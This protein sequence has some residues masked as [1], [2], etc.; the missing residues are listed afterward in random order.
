V[1]DPRLTRVSG[2]Q[3]IVSCAIFAALFSVACRRDPPATAA[4]NG[5]PVSPASA[6]ATQ[7]FPASAFPGPDRRVASIVSATWD[8]EDARDRV[9]EADTVMSLL[10]IG[11]GMGV[12][13]IG[14][15]SG[16]YTVRLSPR[17]GPTGRVYAEDITPDYIADLR[18]RIRR[19]NLNSR[20]R[21]NDST[22]IANVDI[23]LGT[24]DD[25]RLPA[26]AVDRA[27]FVHMYHEIEQ[28]YALMYNLF[29]ALKPGA[30]VG[31]V[32]VDKPTSRHGTPPALLKCEMAAAGYDQV[33]F[34]S[35]AVGYLA[36]FAPVRRSSPDDVRAAIAKPG[37]S[38]G[39]C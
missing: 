30:K 21:G 29:P 19:D 25:P 12:A 11:V 39:R 33:E 10:G 22:S 20:A 13:D 14:A 37:F 38:E 9:G 23:I 35:L 8:N 16:Y 34:H 32:D 1:R 17:V 7:A 27:L 3:W 15:G 4:A 6:T 26:A 36:V 2:R 18:Q 31:V 24:P 28:P 5:E